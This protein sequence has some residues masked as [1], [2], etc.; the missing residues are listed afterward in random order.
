VKLGQKGSLLARPRE[1]SVAA[2][3]VVRYGRAYPD[4]VVEHLAATLEEAGVA[5]WFE[6]CP[7]RTGI[8][9]EVEAAAL[10]DPSTRTIGDAVAATAMLRSRQAR[11]R[12]A[13][14]VAL[15]GHRRGARAGV[16][17]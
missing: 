15:G 8:A 1:P 3:I 10:L 12:T 9:V 16:R 2:R 5:A 11:P 7:G 17:F 13:R 6:G 4:A 14:A